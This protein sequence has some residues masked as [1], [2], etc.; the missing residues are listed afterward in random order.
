MIRRPCLCTIPSLCFRRGRLKLTPTGFDMIKKIK[1]HYI[2]D[3]I[4]QRPTIRRLVRKSDNVGIKTT[5]KSET[6]QTLEY[7]V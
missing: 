5:F 6:H 7:R 1:E 2:E 4:Q 3:K